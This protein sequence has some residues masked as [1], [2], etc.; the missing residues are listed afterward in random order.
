MAVDFPATL[1]VPPGYR[2]GVLLRPASG[3]FLWQRARTVLFHNA[4][5]AYLQ[6]GEAGRYLMT[7]YLESAENE[8]GRKEWILQGNEWLSL[9][10]EISDEANQVLKISFSK[11]QMDT[12]ARSLESQD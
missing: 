7:P 8:K 6:L 3:P 11:A 1:A 4:N 12:A 2:L 5:R 9:P 10:F